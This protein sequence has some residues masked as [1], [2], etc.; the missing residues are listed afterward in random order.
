MTLYL[1]LT[2]SPPPQR[3]LLCFVQSLSYRRPSTVPFL[4]VRMCNSYCILGSPATATV[5]VRGESAA[6]RLVQVFISFSPLSLSP[7]PLSPTP[8]SPLP[9]PKYWVSHI[10]LRCLCVS[11]PFTTPPHTHPFPLPLPS[12]PHIFTPLPPILTHFTD[13]RGGSG[14]A[15]PSE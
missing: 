4:T 5:A 14:V 8:L 12:H 3:S 10:S 7:T 6:T 1:L 9:S 11:L 15:V 13:K 2:S